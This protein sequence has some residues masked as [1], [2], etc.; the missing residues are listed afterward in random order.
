[1]ITATFAANNGT[2]DKGC[3]C[4]GTNALLA[5]RLMGQ[6]QRPHQ[7]EIAGIAVGMPP[8]RRAIIAGKPLNTSVNIKPGNTNQS[9]EALG[10]APIV[11][12]HSPA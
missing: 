1:M 10:N 3:A 9:I 7:G 11:K 8:A 5:H 12:C 6:E 4:F 2:K